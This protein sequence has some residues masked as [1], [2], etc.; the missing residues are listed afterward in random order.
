MKKQNN[1]G[2]KQQNDFEK[3]KK[4]LPE[5]INLVDNSK[6]KGIHRVV[7][8]LQAFPGHPEMFYKVIKWLCDEEFSI[9]IIPD[10]RKN[11]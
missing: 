3:I 8:T 9:T 7:M 10:S 11:D 6:E 4:S 5:L 2:M 1:L